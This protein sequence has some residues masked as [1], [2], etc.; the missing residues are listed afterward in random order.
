MG[1][2]RGL[3]Q[4]PSPPCFRHSHN[5]AFAHPMTGT[6]TGNPTS[7]NSDQTGSEAEGIWRRGGTDY[8]SRKHVARIG[9]TRH[10]AGKSNEK[11]KLNGANNPLSSCTKHW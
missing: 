2:S 7:L 3:Q 9:Q 4:P 5:K 10:D 6:A 1:L 8:Y 11:C